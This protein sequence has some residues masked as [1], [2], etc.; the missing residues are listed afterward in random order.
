MRATRGSEKVAEGC[1]NALVFLMGEHA[2]L[3]NARRELFQNG[4]RRVRARIVQTHD[5]PVLQAVSQST[6]HAVVLQDDSLNA[7]LFVVR[8]QYYREDHSGT[9]PTALVERGRIAGKLRI[10]AAT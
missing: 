8:G 9:S 3:G 5:L 6:E 1:I 2:E 10:A 4:W 7:A